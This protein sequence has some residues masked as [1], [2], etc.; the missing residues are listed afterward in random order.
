MG[1]RDV[2]A[3]RAHPADYASRVSVWRGEELLAAELDHVW[4]P[5][6]APSGALL[7]WTLQDQGSASEALTLRLEL[8]GWSLPQGVVAERLYL[9]RLRDGGWQPLDGQVND[10]RYL[11]G[12]F[13]AGDTLGVLPAPADVSGYARQWQANG[14]SVYAD[15]AAWGRLQ[16]SPASISFFGHSPSGSAVT[17]TMSGLPVDASRE[18]VREVQ[19]QLATQAVAATGELNWSVAGGEGQLLWLQR[20]A[21]PVIIGS[22][23]GYTDGCAQ[24][25]V[26][27]GNV[28]TLGDDIVG[29]VMIVA[30]SQVLDCAGHSILQ[31]SLD[32]GAGVGVLVPGP[33]QGHAVLDGVELRNCVIGAPGAA[34]WQG[35]LVNGATNAVVA[36]NALHSNRYG[37]TVLASQDAQIVGNDIVSGDYG[38]G[39][40]ALAYPTTGTVI[41]DNSISLGYLA[42]GIELSGMMSGEIL[43]VTDSWVAYNTIVGGAS[44]GGILLR[45]AEDNQLTANVMSGDGQQSLG[46]GVSI[47]DDGW[48][49][50]LWWN[51]I[52]ATQGANSINGAAELSHEQQGNWWGHACP[53]PLFVAGVDSNDRDVLDSYPYAGPNSWSFGAAPGCDTTAPAAPQLTE[54]PSGASIISLRPFFVGNTEPYA[55]LTFSEGQSVLGTARARANG[56]FVFVPDSDF[57]AGAHTV[58]LTATDYAGNTSTTVSRSFSLVEVSP[59]QP[60]WNSAGTF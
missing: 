28:C 53:N 6:T 55:L 37:I 54:P 42:Q 17:F 18:L 45:I 7:A 30:S 9:A 8:T 20:S 27:D 16:V 3:S 33:A 46:V 60:L 26:R 15:E 34:F 14:I 22:A 48:P 21:T 12:Q 40:Q 43:P 49:N 38:V 24:V 11:Q 10:G 41:S 47:G 32:H 25:G 51:S 1:E 19:G 57:D 2:G 23:S 39:I 44:A 4:E 31:S 5:G 59:S 50:A 36:D 29:P 58:T 52:E 35:I 56:A 13:D